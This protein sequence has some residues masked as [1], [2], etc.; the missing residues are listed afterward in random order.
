MAN[1][2]FAAQIIQMMQADLALRD[3][4]IQSGK[5]NGGYNA[6]MEQL[7]HDNAK[8]LNE[9]IDQIAYPIIEKV[10]IE[11]NEAA[12]VIIQH[13]ISQPHFMKK[14]LTLLNEAVNENKANPKHLAYLSDRIAVFEGRPQLFGTQFDWDE[15]GELHP[16]HFDKLTKVNER[17]K[18]IGLNTLEEQ[19]EIIR[20]QASKENQTPPIDFEKRK[21]TYDEWRKKVG[22]IK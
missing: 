2:K 22:W 16:N 18:A 11:A 5:H 3:E 21:K 4:L 7:H 19:L 14:C 17:R 20:Q 6:Q 13:A 9:I 12:W 15:K 10:G 1:E 8:K